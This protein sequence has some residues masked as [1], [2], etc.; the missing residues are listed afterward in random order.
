VHDLTLQLHRYE[1]LDPSQI[2]AA[3]AALVDPAVPE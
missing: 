2:A 1:D 3:V